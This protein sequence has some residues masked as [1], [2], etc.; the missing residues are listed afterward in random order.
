MPHTTPGHTLTTQCHTHTSSIRITRH[1]PSIQADW[2]VIVGH[3][4][5]NFAVYTYAT[6]SIY[7]ATMTLVQVRQI[8]RPCIRRE[9]VYLFR[10]AIRVAEILVAAVA[11]G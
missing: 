7:G 5:K 8:A 1:F 6:H 3:D 2:G 9:C 10:T 4:N 11:G